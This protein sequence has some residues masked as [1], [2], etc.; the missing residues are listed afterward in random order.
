MNKSTNIEEL[1]TFSYI[2]HNLSFTSSPFTSST[3]MSIASFQ[4]T[5]HVQVDLVL[6]TG[7]RGTRHNWTRQ[8][9]FQPTEVNICVSNQYQTWLLFI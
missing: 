6:L 4:P 8:D 9:A 2:A 1:F 3:S 7:L 5:C